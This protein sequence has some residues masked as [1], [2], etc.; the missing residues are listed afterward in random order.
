MSFQADAKKRHRAEV[1][2]ILSGLKSCIEKA[3]REQQE[4]PP[5]PRN[6]ISVV[7]ETAEGVRGTQHDSDG[8]RIEVK[9]GGRVV[10][11]AYL[12]SVD[13]QGEIRIADVSSGY[14]VLPVL[15]VSTTSGL[16]CKLVVSSVER[17]FDAVSGRVS[18]SRDDMRWVSAAWVGLRKDGQE[19]D[20]EGDATVKLTY[21][22]PPSDAVPGIKTFKLAFKQSQME[23]MWQR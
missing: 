11:A 13:C 1:G 5:H 22:L 16:I 8:V 15:L 4:T 10:F 6:A 7:V 19:G 14:T 2:R 23:K 17:C 18:I 12:L 21:S 9:V 3:I 20:G